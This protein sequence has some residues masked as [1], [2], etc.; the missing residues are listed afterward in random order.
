[1]RRR[2]DRRKFGIG[3]R[4]FHSRAKLIIDKHVHGLREGL[5][6]LH[7]GFGRTISLLRHYRGKKGVGC[8][9]GDVEICELELKVRAVFCRA[10]DA[11][12]RCTRT[13]VKWLPRKQRASGAAPG[14]P[15]AC[16]REHRTRKGRNHRLRQQ[17]AGDIVVGGAICLPIQVG[18]RQVSSSR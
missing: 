1:M 11:Y 8:S 3:A 12:I 10:S 16:I 18:A 17:K 9:R 7:I 14:C 2:S 6:T 5:A 4:T 13:E 15:V